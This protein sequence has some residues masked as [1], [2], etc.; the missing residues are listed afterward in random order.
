VYVDTVGNGSTVVGYARVSSEEQGASGSSLQSQRTEIEAECARRGWRLLRIDRD[1]LSGKNLKRPGLNAALAA[2]RSGEVEGIVVH[3]LDRLSRSIVDFSRLL[4]DARKRGFNIVALD[5]GLDL[6][7][8]QG[9]LVG[10]VIASVAQWERRIIGQRTREALAVKRREGVQVGRPRSLPESTVRRLRAARRR[11]LSYAEIAA[12]LNRDDVPTAHGGSRW[13]ASTVRSALL[14][15][16]RGSADDQR[17]GDGKGGL[18]VV[19]ASSSAP[20]S[21]RRAKS[22]RSMN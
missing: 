21:S 7:T 19:A 9:E 8:P 10:N 5:L 1:V 12:R 17:A 11:G 13:H 3:K 4:E 20:S 15:R 2:C 14:A 18:G 6:S 22:V 16:T